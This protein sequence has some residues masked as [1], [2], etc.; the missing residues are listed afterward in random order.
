MEQ[1]QEQDPAFRTGIATM[2]S[3]AC[4]GNAGQVG[5]VCIHPPE[6]CIHP[7]EQDPVV[8]TGIASTV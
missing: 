5:E 7:P 2:A 1:E 8:R 3:F 6:V 4:R